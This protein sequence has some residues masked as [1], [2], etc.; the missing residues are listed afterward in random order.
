MEMWE[1]SPPKM[2]HFDQSENGKLCLQNFCL[3]KNLVSISLHLLPRVHL[4][5]I[6]NLLWFHLFWHQQIYTSSDTIP[7]NFVI[8]LFVLRK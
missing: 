2:I 5:L 6:P 3:Q 7:H 1:N 8:S 4:K